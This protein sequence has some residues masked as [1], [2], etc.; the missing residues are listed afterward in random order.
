M[1]SFELDKTDLQRLKTALEG[2]DAT[3]QEVLK[4][5]HASEIAMLFE[6]LPQEA[7]ERII[8][9]LPTEIASEVIS[10]MDEEHRPGELLI[11][12]DP[13]KRSEIVEE[14]DYDDATDIIS[15]LDEED[16]EEILEDIDK[17]DADSIRALMK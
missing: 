13:E 11:N 15:Q 5:Y 6:K 14:L 9:I 1:Q 7:K 3:L 8:N 4:E 12:L 2:N 17:E 16:Q 10:E